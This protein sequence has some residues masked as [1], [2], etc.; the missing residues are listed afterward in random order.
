MNSDFDRER[1]G[2]TWSNFMPGGGMTMW[3]AANDDFWAPEPDR[4]LLP[5]PPS[6]DEIWSEPREHHDKKEEGTVVKEEVPSS[7]DSPPPPSRPF[8]DDRERRP[9]KPWQRP[10]KKGYRDQDD[11]DRRYSG[12]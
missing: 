5:P 9:L 6:D 8:D 7:H 2:M 3:S 1:R 10:G 11:E 12:K 4:R